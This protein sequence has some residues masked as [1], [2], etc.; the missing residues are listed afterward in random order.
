VE[1]INQFEF[2]DLGQTLERLKT[3]GEDN[4]AASAAFSPV[5]SGERVMMALIGGKPIEL[6]VSRAAAVKLQRELAEVKEEH[7]RRDGEDGSRKWKFPD[8]ET[9]PL[10]SWDWHSVA[11]AL[12][13]FE[14]V[15]QEEMREAATYRVPSRG[16][17]DT[18][19]LVDAADCAFPPELLPVIPQKTRDDW[20]A[21]GRCLAFNLL[22]A[23]GFHVARAVE[24]MVEAYYTL[25]TGKQKTLN[26]WNDYIKA[27]ESPGINGALIPS[28]KV[29]SELK[30]MKDDYRNPLV[31]PRVVLSEPDARMLFANGESVIIAMA[32]E[33]WALQ[34]KITPNALLAVTAAE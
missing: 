18:A 11:T 20:K 6:G 30:Q 1:R 14:T 8:S 19:K 2:Y 28:E 31:H 3:L 4:I 17:F 15:F 33:I 23:S 21:A 25:S 34:A 7:F 22:S 24:A 27:L 13:S 10:R 16:I 29:I 12:K 9:P 32:Q 26:G 5:I